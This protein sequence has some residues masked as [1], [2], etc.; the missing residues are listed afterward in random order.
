VPSHASATSHAGD[1]AIVVDAAHAIPRDELDVRASR[2]GGPGG[3]HVNVTSS[4]IEVRWNPGRSRALSPEE[5]VRVAAKLASRI[6]T[7]GV[8]RVVS[9]STRSQK[10]NRELAEQRLAELVRH[11]LV[12]PKPRKKTRPSRAAREKRLV[13]KK[14]NAEKKRERRGDWD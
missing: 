2:A 14:R 3:Q 10:Q 6:D 1:R 13:G 9:S 4:R 11:A 5:R 7:E 8:L 12:V